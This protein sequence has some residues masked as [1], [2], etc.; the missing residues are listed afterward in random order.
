MAIEERRRLVLWLVTLGVVGLATLSLLA[1]FAPLFD[2]FAWLE[3][4]REVVHLDLDTSAGPSW[5]PLPVIVSVPLAFTGDAAAEL[6]LLLIRVAWLTSLILAWR[7]AGRLMF[8]V[9]VATGLAVRFAPRRVRLARRLAGAAA[10]IGLIL[11]FDPFT[12]WARQ[13]VGGLS[14][15]L[16]VALVLGAIDR[17][18]SHRSGQALALGAAAAL[19]RPE[20]WPLLGIYGIWLWRRDPRLRPWL[21][22]SAVAL[23]VLWIVPDLIA[24]GDA[25]TGAER[26]RDV[27]GSFFGEAAEAVGRALNMPLA[28]LWVGVIV[29]VASAREHRERE[30][31]VLAAGALGWI[32]VVA[33]LAGAGYA[34]IPRF[35][36]PAAAVACVLGGVGL[37]R[38]LAA[39]DGMRTRDRRRRRAIALA[40]VV[41]AGFA[42][43]SAFRVVDLPTV[44]DDAADYGRHVHGFEALADSLGRDRLTECG[45]VTNTEF[46]TQTAI[47]WKLEIPIADVHIRVA[48][49]PPAGVAIVSPGASM[50]ARTA[51]ER[52]GALQGTHAGWLVYEIS[53]DAT[54]SNEAANGAAIAG[55]SG[56]S[57]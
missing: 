22:T 38:L 51:V 43:Q 41:I 12:A 11:L 55:V 39:I 31:L 28:A 18:L 2:P 14:E 29:S 42:V 7:L 49:A 24:S 6:W 54:A 57:R 35:A 19:L 10:V 50:L 20:A 32:A 21:I 48:T 17:A 13:V 34:G 44:L 26:A 45:E 4:G 9:R 8:P 5:K 33:V 37:V 25:L 3:W 47:A 23:P 27:N 36:A 53:C 40:A 46:L 16:L 52:D 56:A 15:P 30:I 1:P